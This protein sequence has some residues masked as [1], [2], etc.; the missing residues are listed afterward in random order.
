MDQEECLAR[1][2]LTS[3]IPGCVYD[4]QARQVIRWRDVDAPDH[5]R[6]LNTFSCLVDP[7]IRS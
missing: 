4:A 6:G 1:G 3:R 5:E 2:G 7:E